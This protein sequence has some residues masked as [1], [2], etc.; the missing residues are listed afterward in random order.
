MAVKVMDKSDIK[1]QEMTMNVRREIA[2]MKALKHKNIVNLRHVLTSA[3]KL[4]V[5]M[6]LVTGGEL[7]TKILNEGKLPEN[8]AR[9]F[10]QQLIDGVDYCHRRGVCHRDL[11]VCVAFL[12]ATVGSACL[13]LLC[14]LC[15]SAVS[16]C[17]FG[18]LTRE[19]YSSCDLPVGLYC[20]RMRCVWQPE[21]L[22]IDDTNGELKITDFGLSAMKGASTT[23][24]LL[25]TQC[26]SPNYCAPEI[27]SR[28]KQGYS[29]P[30]VDAW[31]C[32]I[33]LFALLAG[34]LP[35]Y[36]ENTKALY[37]MIQRSDVVFPRAFPRG[38]RTLVE[39]L[40]HKD[41]ERRLKLA[42]VKRDP[43]FVI[44]YEG[45]N[46]R[47]AE[48][49]E[50]PAAAGVNR[51]RSS[52]RKRPKR[53][54]EEPA[55]T[56]STETLPSS[57]AGSSGTVTAPPPRPR[58]VTAD[59]LPLDA[60]AAEASSRRDSEAAAAAAAAAT[61]AAAAAAAVAA[62]AASAAATSPSP[63]GDKRA[64]V[65]APDGAV[66]PQPVPPLASPSSMPVSETPAAQPDAGVKDRAAAL[67]T[68]AEDAPSPAVSPVQEELAVDQST[69]P[70]PLSYLP[71]VAEES[72]TIFTGVHESGN[73]DDSDPVLNRAVAGATDGVAAP[74][75]TLMASGGAN[76]SAT[77][78]AHSPSEATS[79]DLS[80][81]VGVD[82][83]RS[84]EVE[85][86]GWPTTSTAPQVVVI[87]N[88]STAD[89]E[90][91]P[92]TP[93][94]A[95]NSM[96]LSFASSKESSRSARALAD[97]VGAD[98][99][100]VAA[101]E[102]V[103][104]N[105]RASSTSPSGLALPSSPPCPQRDF[106][107]FPST[108]TMEQ[109][110]VSRAHEDPHAL[111]LRSVFAAVVGGRQDSVMRRA[112]DASASD[113]DVQRTEQ[114]SLP[115]W[116]QKQLT[117]VHRA[118]SPVAPTA[119]SREPHRADLEEGFPRRRS[120]ADVGSPLDAG[121]IFG[122]H[123]S[124]RSSE[125]GES[126]AVSIA[127]A[128]SRDGTEPAVADKSTALATVPSSGSVGAP[129]DGA[130]EESAPP[131]DP[132]PAV[133]APVTVVESEPA[134]PSR[135]EQ[136]RRLFESSASVIRAPSDEYSFRQP[137]S[138]LVYAPAVLPALSARWPPLSSAD[139]VDSS[140]PAAAERSEVER[141]QSGD[142]VESRDGASSAEISAGA[143]EL[144][145]REV[146]GDP[147]AHGNPG[148]S[149]DREVFADHAGP[150]DE[151]PADPEA[152]ADEAVLVAEADGPVG[153]A[154]EPSNQG[155]VDTYEPPAAGGS[156]VVFPPGVSVC[157]S[158]DAVGAEADLAKRESRSFAEATLPSYP[159]N[160]FEDAEAAMEEEDLATAAAGLG[161]P[162]LAAADSTALAA[163]G[164]Q[165]ARQPVAVEP[166]L[167]AYQVLGRAVPDAPMS[168][169]PLQPIKDNERAVEEPALKELAGPPDASLDTHDSDVEHEDEPEDDDPRSVPAHRI[170][171]AVQRYQKL[172]QLEKGVGILASPSFK[173]RSANVGNQ[174]QFGRLAA[175]EG[176]LPVEPQDEAAEAASLAVSTET[177]Q[178]YRDAKS[179]TGMWGILLVQE[180][181]G[182]QRAANG[183]TI[184]T[185][186]A[187]QS[188][189]LEEI[190]AF[191][192]LLDFWQRQ[193]DR[194]HT[195]DDITPLPDNEAASLRALLSTLRPP[196]ADDVGEAVEIVDADEAQVLLS[197]EQSAAG[198]QIDE[199]DDTAT[200]T[201][202]LVRTEAGTAGHGDSFHS[203]ASNEDGEDHRTD[204]DGRSVD[205]KDSVVVRS[206]MKHST[207][208]E[209][210]SPPGAPESVGRRSGS[211]P[212]L[213]PDEG[214]SPNGSADANG[215]G[216]L[217]AMAL[218]TS[219][220]ASKRPPKHS[221][222]GSNGSGM[223][224][225]RSGSNHGGGQTGGLGRKLLPSE[226]SADGLET[227]ASAKSGSAGAPL[228]AGDSTVAGMSASDVGGLKG[229]ASYSSVGSS[230][231]GNGAGSS[232]SAPVARSRWGFRGM[233]GLL[234]GAAVAPPPPVP[235]APMTEF[236]SALPPEKCA[237]VLGRVLT[238]MNCNVMM[239][240]GESKVR[241]EYPMKRGEK[242]LV[243]VSAHRDVHAGET[244]ISFK[245][246][247]RDRSRTTGS[248]EFSEFVANVH[249]NFRRATGGGG[250]GP[251]R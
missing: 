200:D 30:L 243:S 245:R 237:L 90:L 66:C 15:P 124:R 144:V 43:W 171:A 184:V 136:A 109:P 40:L 44:D 197:Q 23:E 18:V 78:I 242:L 172:F 117:P 67:G 238:S 217:P 239:K 135:I 246:S 232:S 24:E 55:P 16:P 89:R 205:G 48:G 63:T 152:S 215:G 207:T 225:S 224:S 219:A 17:V 214:D 20:S 212:Q 157:P 186:D 75:A 84:A 65:P 233:F 170:K 140:I 142:A 179:V 248:P 236:K 221:R 229:G 188:I 27:I 3:T 125:P 201:P 158:S 127:A 72:S 208:T 167:A 91:S 14:L 74:P 9:R 53:R 182:R 60:A 161:L 1:A 227:L 123:L 202:G 101:T 70:A 176:V 112:S 107:T 46:A 226:K 160:D 244:V 10:F 8:V 34:Y 155:N 163:D 189:S 81:R 206:G 111:E 139:A 19:R 47:P 29:G 37:R 130:A 118:S 132:S 151:H 191:E 162:L 69:G 128:A 156:D 213:Q 141:D 110:I 154:E 6:D 196:P 173:S 190:D 2:I 80:G 116:A 50:S 76:P 131:S 56:G 79:A 115:F 249:T 198:E 22:L 82:A 218:S 35:F 204:S 45:D 100:A 250:G 126:P 33:I 85:R 209:D 210:F 138:P 143:Q 25:H 234:T 52:R 71:S 153:E 36:D 73:A 12:L 113:G 137:T 199:P 51:G 122:V 99:D 94:D 223:F 61:A 105:G 192:R 240:K 241:A 114:P 31:S 88:S 148:E 98:E 97:G 177:L 68:A 121:A 174:K 49:T 7:F 193:R 147:G 28:A 106:A 120:A 187:K 195:L 228:P 39:R 5:V 64:A 149:G 235:T 168:P 32:G 41:P 26:G 21:N 54:Q 62:A 211:A 194:D 87:P 93:A 57:A 133:A 150:V 169:S 58:P 166:D 103:P 175:F 96:L 104:A 129:D 203:R 92:V 159:M 108:K 59:P 180:G 95:R 164:S 251:A 146:P 38:A 77:D 165:P 83:P 145:G 247:R 102:S 220:D 185:P 231:G 183:P 11:K 181:I 178:L 86:G 230:G 134:V 13:C 42:D 119:S 222:N 216:A 4:Y